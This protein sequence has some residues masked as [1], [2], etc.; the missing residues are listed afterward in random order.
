MAGYVVRVEGIAGAIAGIEGL[1]LNIKRKAALQV[2]DG[3]TRRM[4]VDTGRA[5][6]GTQTSLGSPATADNGRLD[7]SGAEVLAEASGTVAGAQ[8]GQDIFVANAVPYVQYLEDGSSKQ[9]PG[10]MFAVT[11]E[12]V[13]AQ[14]NG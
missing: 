11:V 9:A 1:A 4:P 5:R 7:R 6:G 13:V 10:G 3:V 2:A 8:L 12:D 14:F